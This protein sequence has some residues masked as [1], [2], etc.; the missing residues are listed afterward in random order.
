MIIAPINIPLLFPAPPITKAAQTKK[1]DFAGDMKLG[2]N[3][4]NFQAQKA[5][6]KAAIAP[7]NARLLA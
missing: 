6:A 3:P 1:V 2:W 5:P 7:P 4:V